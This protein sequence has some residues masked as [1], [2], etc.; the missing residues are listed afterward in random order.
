MT[1]LLVKEH[2]KSELSDP[3]PDPCLKKGKRQ[4]HGTNLG[5]HPRFMLYATLRNNIVP[6]RLCLTFLFSLVQ[7]CQRFVR[8]L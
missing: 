4:E 1:L 3:C 8:K 5:L 6:I 7:I 2:R